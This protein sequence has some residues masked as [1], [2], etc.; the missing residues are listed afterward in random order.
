MIGAKR[1]DIFVG[2]FPAMVVLRFVFN[3]LL[4]TIIIISSSATRSTKPIVKTTSAACQVRVFGKTV[5]KVPLRYRD[6]DSPYALAVA[7]FS[8]EPLVDSSSDSSSGSV[9]SAVDAD[10]SPASPPTTM[11][12][13]ATQVWPSA[14][15]AARALERYMNP[16]W[17]ICEFGCG[18]GL[19]SLVAASLGADKVYATD[20]DATGL[21][22]VKLAA[23]QQGLENIEA[24]T[25]DLTDNHDRELP[26]AD[27]YL[28]SDVFESAKVAIGAAA[29]CYRL[30]GQQHQPRKD[31]ASC[32]APPLVLLPHVWVFAQA[33][34]VQREFFLKEMQRL[35]NDPSLS[36]ST[37]SNLEEEKA[38]A[39]NSTRLWL[40]D[41]DEMNVF[42]G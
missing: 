4:L 18:P 13:L 16:S 33:D 20:V 23:K 36:W 14:R 19:P 8:D 7:A 10:P 32:P 12:F 3:L 30:L 37:A 21:E 1:F 40:C 39:L 2:F 26:Q 31:D 38:R 25:F 5:Q 29:I 41:L 27:L 9:G 42:Y 17:R 35:L 28:F 11:N 24:R 34:R 22:L 6:D 15:T